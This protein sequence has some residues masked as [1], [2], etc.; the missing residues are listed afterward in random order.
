MAEP[1]R[2]SAAE[3]ID[4]VLDE[5][6]WTSWDTAARPLRHL[7][8]VRRR[9]RRRAGPQR[10][11]RSG[12]H[13]GGQAPRRSPGR[14][15]D[16]LG[17]LLSRRVDRPSPPPTGSSGP[18]RAGERRGTPAAGRP[19]PQVGP[20]CRRASSPFSC[21]WC[22]SPR[23]SWHTR[24]AGLPY[25][26]YLRHP[27]TGGVMASWGSLGHVTVAEP[28]ALLGFLGPR[29]YEAL[30]GEPFPEGVQTAE[31]LFANGLVDARRS[32]RGRADLLAGRSHPDGA[33]ARRR[34]RARRR[35]RAVARRRHLGPVTR[36]RRPD[37]PGVD[38]CCGTPPPTRSR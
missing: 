15:S 34:P 3:L 21:R 37:R 18:S 2:L 38:G 30:Y 13:R 22:G 35:R 32:A 36:S 25:L 9:A 12:R 6:S 26:V 28:G 11:R 33:A 29:V 24:A 19:S 4:L 5:D 23:R 31:N 16:R 10:R 14:V 8:G 7:R 27:T 1:Q 17:V 20:A